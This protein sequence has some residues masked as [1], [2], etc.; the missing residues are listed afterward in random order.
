M[1]N[2]YD[3][4]TEQKQLELVKRGSYS[5]H[6][7]SSPSELVQIAAVKKEPSLIRFITP[8]AIF[9]SAYALALSL[10]PSIKNEDWFKSINKE[11]L[12]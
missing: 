2:Y 1:S 8:K 11:D 12:R 6:F 4:M 3:D 5:I 7:I 9:K 10:Y